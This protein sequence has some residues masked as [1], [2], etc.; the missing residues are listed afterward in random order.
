MLKNGCLAKV[1]NAQAVLSHSKSL[2]KPK[3]TMMQ[4]PGRGSRLKKHER[5]GRHELGSWDEIWRL[6]LEEPVK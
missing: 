2:H 5:L 6:D 1:I 3:I 4:F